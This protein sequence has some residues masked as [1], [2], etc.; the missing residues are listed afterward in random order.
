MFSEPY[1]TSLL[2]GYPVKKLTDQLEVHFIEGQLTPVTLFEHAPERAAQWGDVLFEIDPRVGDIDTMVSPKGI[3][4]RSG[5]KVVLDARGLKRERRDGPPVIIS[6]A[7]YRFAVREALL[8]YLWMND[9]PMAF[10]QLGILPIRV[11]A[12]WVSEGLTRSLGL[13]PLDQM[14]L[15][16]LAGYY[17]MCQFQSNETTALSPTQL[18]GMA[19]ILSRAL[20]IKIEDVMHAL[21]GLPILTDLAS[22]MATVKG[23]GA[24]LRFEQANNGLL[25]TKLGGTWYGARAR[26]IVG[27][28]LEYPPTFVTMLLSAYA[29]RTYHSSYFAKLAAN[30]DRQQLSRDFV[31]AMNHLSQGLTG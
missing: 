7:D 24:S 4:T 5:L 8:T 28:A 14:R 1:Q 22:F 20:A 3:M 27:V 15:S 31:L 25:Y 12:R 6:A 13:D 10:S 9:G 16:I 30:A 2:R 23:D 19:N 21:T 26:T 18:V 11:Y 29:D 17:Y